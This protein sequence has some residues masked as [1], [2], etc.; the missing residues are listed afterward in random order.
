MFTRSDANGDGVIS[1]DEM[2]ETFKQA[3]QNEKRHDPSTPIPDFEVLSACATCGRVA[4]RSRP[5][6]RRTAW[7]AQELPDETVTGIDTDSDGVIS[8]EEMRAR[9]LCA[10]ARLGAPTP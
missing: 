10:P 9:S 7:I 3:Q 5:R 2:R 1:Y 6:A 4:D 8:P